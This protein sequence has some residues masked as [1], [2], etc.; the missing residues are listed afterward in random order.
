M[1]ELQREYGARGLWVLAIDVDQGET[2]EDLARFRD[3]AGDP[4]YDW[5]LDTGGRMMQALAIRSLD[6]TLLVSPNGEVLF[7]SES[8]PNPNTLRRAVQLAL[9]L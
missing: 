2:A 1:A 6:A 8:L 5:A 3:L 4:Q 7:R 9:G